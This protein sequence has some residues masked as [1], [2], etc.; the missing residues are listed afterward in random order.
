M[1]T[2]LALFA[3]LSTGSAAESRSVWKFDFGTGRVAPGFVQVGKDGVYSKQAG[4]GFL[5]ESPTGDKPF[6]FAVDLPEGN[7]DVA[8]KLGDSAGDSETTVK[9]E[10]RELMLENVRTSSGEFV[11]RRFT[12]N[13]RTPELPGA[14][15]V[16]LDMRELGPPMVAHWDDR[17]TLEFNGAR[18]RV[19]TLEIMKAPEATTIFIAG[20]STVTQQPEEPW[21]GWGQMLTRFFKPGVA[22]ANYAQSGLALYTFKAQ[23]R[24]AKVLSSMKRGDWFL[25]Q[26]GHND[27][28]D[29]TPGAGPF[30]SYTENLRLFINEAR[31]KGARPVLVTPMERRRWSPDRTPQSTLADYAEAVRRV[32]K[33]L[34]VPVIDLNA[35]SLKLYQALGP[36]GSKKAFVH[37]PAGTFPGQD[38]PLKDD[39]HHNVYGGYE[40]AK[41]VVEGIK[42]NVPEL[43][44]HLLN[45]MPAFDP[46]HPDPPESVQI[47]PSPAV[48]TT[49]PL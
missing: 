37:Y 29:Q 12:V 22:V 15:Q 6:Y 13:I 1:K 19:A 10:S 20:D 49:P 47:P 23:G 25:I 48:S 4:F 34:D 45:N 44:K 42:A 11:T 2:S 17:L 33:E 27:Q 30:T 32:G 31:K 35:M 43:A 40:L 26:F 5:G 39:T 41:C 7:Y 14:G 16:C 21:A 8:V 3:A 9:A 24:L 46:G 38:E 18:P 28:K 36:E